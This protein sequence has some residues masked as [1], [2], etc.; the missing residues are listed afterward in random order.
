MSFALA[1]Q[2][3]TNTSRD[4][5]ISTTAKSTH[6][7]HSTNNFNKNSSDS[8]FY[9]QPNVGNQAA[10]NLMRSKNNPVEFDFS[11]I[12]IQPK[13]KVGQPTDA[14]EQSTQL[15]PRN[16]VSTENDAP[17]SP[18]FDGPQLFSIQEPPSREKS[19][20]EIPSLEESEES[21]EQPVGGGT[22]PAGPTV[23]MAESCGQPRNMNKITSGALLGGLTI[24]SYY[25]DLK[26]R[27]YPST[28]GPFDT[29]SRAGANVQLCGVI[30]SPCLPSQFHLEQTVT[31]T[32]DRVNGVIDS[33]EGQTFD[34]I[35]K[36]GRD[37]SNAPFRQEFLGGGRA[38][39][40]YIISMADPPSIAYNSTSR[41]NVE[42][43]RNFVTSLVGPSGRQSVSWSLSIRVSGGAVT[44]DVLT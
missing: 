37:S 11:K 3:N 38:P 15:R 12:D 21:D 41:S 29:G 39:L 18:D 19:N 2:K 44:S 33:T 24:N 27:G 43:D 17:I 8:I 14:Y 36:S 22:S 7:Y 23:V 30:P 28:A 32:R 10:E 34:D 31:R 42:W 5:K 1:H 6:A 4:D 13:L 35:A 9:L 25:P 20:I 40:G 26:S 16:A